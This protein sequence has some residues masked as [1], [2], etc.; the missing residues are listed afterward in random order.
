MSILRRI[1]N[2]IFTSSDERWPVWLTGGKTDSGVAINAE[3][4]KTIATVWQA[5][6]VISRDVAQLPIDV[7]SR[8]AN[9]DK[10][11]EATHPAQWLLRTRPNRFMTAFHFKQTLMGHVLLWGNAY[12]YIERDR[13]GNPI[14]LWPLSPDQTTP[15]VTEA[16]QLQYKTRIG[17]MNPVERTFTASEVLHIRGLGF[18]GIRGYSVVTMA[19]ESF[20]LT[21]A[22]EKHGARYFGNFA[23]PQGLLKIPGHRPTTETIEQVRNDWKKVTSGERAHD[24]AI[25]HG[26]WEFSAIGMS[27]KDSQ[28]LEARKFQKNEVASW[29]MLPPHKVGDLERATFTNIEE[30]NRDYLNTSLMAW[31]CIWQEE[32]D[33]KLLTREEQEGRSHF[34]EFNTAALLRGDVDSRFSAYGKA[35]NDGWLNR[36]EV[37]QMENLNR[38]DGLD[39]YLV[40]LNMRDSSDQGVEDGG[41]R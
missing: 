39:E 28:F 27:N 21:K 19:R 16:G 32:A 3:S 26:G 29:F 17:R 8:D 34:F 35:I 31:L 12:A 4:A 13:N 15:E 30:Q 24:V 25:L 11:R 5:V 23:T 41:N 18:D 38:V 40:P 36:N 22:A 10:S 6:N 2:M 37:R 1:S 9:G 7:Y 14:A 33:L 20:G